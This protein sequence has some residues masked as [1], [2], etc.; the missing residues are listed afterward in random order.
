MTECCVRL[1]ESSNVEYAHITLG[2]G[3]RESLVDSLHDVVKQLGVDGF[4]QG[5]SSAVGLS[6]L[7]WNSATQHDG[8]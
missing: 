3:E 8:R 7:Q 5:I 6:Y 1:T 4:C 2:G